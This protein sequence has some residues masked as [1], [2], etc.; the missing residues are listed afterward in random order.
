MML[1]SCSYHHSCQRVVHL[2]RLVVSKR[3]KTSVGYSSKV[4]SERRFAHRLYATGT[5]DG[6][7]SGGGIGDELLDFMYAG[8]KLRK[9]YG[10]QDLVLPDGGI[11][12]RD[13]EDDPDNGSNEFIVRDKVAVMFPE[14]YPMAEQVLLQLI[15]LRALVVVVTKDPAK[16]KSGYGPYVDVVQSDSTK[17]L[18]KGVSRALGMCQSVVLCGSLSGD[19]MS[20]IQKSGVPHVVLLS[21]VSDSTQSRLASFFQSSESK[22]LSDASREAIVQGSGLIYSIVRVDPRALSLTLRGGSSTL[23][24]TKNGKP[25]TNGLEVP[26]EDVA[27]YLAMSAMGEAPSASRVVGLASENVASGA[28]RSTLEEREAMIAE[29]LL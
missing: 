28:S 8:K 9:W 5:N 2:P 26:R 17:F 27:L 14:E 4:L 23:I 20:I 6:E 10:E 29:L 16:A 24:A 18:S 13:T 22:E 15:L 3:A 12:A 21:G 25:P 1:L 7:K 11:A 19:G